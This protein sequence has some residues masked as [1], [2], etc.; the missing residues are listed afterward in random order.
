LRKKF[1]KIENA[2]ASANQTGIYFFFYEAHTNAKML[3]LNN[4]LFVSKRMSG[5]NEEG[6]F[7]IK[8]TKRSNPEERTT[9]DVVHQCQLKK[10]IDEQSDV[11]SLQEDI[12]TL[13]NQIEETSDDLVR[14]QL[15]NQLYRLKQE[16]ETKQNNER[17][18]DYLLDTGDLLF[19]YYDVQDKILQGAKGAT[20]TVIKRKPGD[21]LSALENAA[22]IDVSEKAPDHQD[23][24]I[25][26]DKTSIQENKKSSKKP[27]QKKEN[28]LSRDGLLEKYLLKMYP[29]YV[30]K[31]NEVEDLSGECMECGADMM[32]SQTEAML[33][34][35][36]C[37]ISEFILI[38][39]DRPSYKDPPRES[40]YYAYKRINHFNELLA[41]HQAKGSAEIPQDV[42]D[43]IEAELK[44]QRITDYKNLKYPQMR[45]I[46]RKLKLNRQYDHIPFIISRLNGSI[47]P[48]MSRETEERLRHMFKEIQPSFQK[49]CPKNRRN[50]L[51]YSYVLYKF[52][53][54][55][56]LDEFLASFPLL[57]NRDKLYQQSKVW[58]QICN[59]MQWQY[60][61]TI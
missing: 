7:K 13:T 9:L 40:S 60:I 41:Q 23:Q 18:F 43:Q 42:I 21:V 19:E 31:T 12:S 16:L 24:I 17:V 28:Q 33:Y 35:P 57:K 32:F 58:E 3:C 59:D 52:C 39:S 22:A 29:E 61:P 26:E 27:K 46:L 51:S 50:F 37:G 11:R 55:L 15:E 56:E 49:H 53:E 8:P 45:Q 1:W 36:D 10:I 14:G 25:S 54:L 38:D 6:F 20:T 34:C 44:K 2:I 47:A 48:V 30:K 4:K 5:K